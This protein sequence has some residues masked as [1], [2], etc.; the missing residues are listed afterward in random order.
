M[1]F[2]NNSEGCYWKKLWTDCFTWVSHWNLLR[3]SA[4]YGDLDMWKVQE[5]R[6]GLYADAPVPPN[7]CAAPWSWCHML[8]EG[9]LS[10]PVFHHCFWHKHCHTWHALG[11][12]SPVVNSSLYQKMKSQ[13]ADLSWMDVE[14]DMSYFLDCCTSLRWTVAIMS[15]MQ[16]SLYLLLMEH[17][18]HAVLAAGTPQAVSC[19]I[20]FAGFLGSPRQI[21]AQ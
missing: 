13:H 6:S 2:S 16:L 17:G 18:L 11:N 14:C 20:T 1:P 12:E 10:T 7:A 9:N 8:H 5:E 4:C 15:V 3:L 21:L 19:W